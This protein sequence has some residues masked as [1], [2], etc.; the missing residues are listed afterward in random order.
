MGHIYQIVRQI[1]VNYNSI[2]AILLERIEKSIQKQILV[3]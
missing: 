2:I 1:S 3:R